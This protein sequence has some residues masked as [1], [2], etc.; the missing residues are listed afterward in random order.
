MS[1]REGLQQGRVCNKA[2]GLCSFSPK[3]LTINRLGIDTLFTAPQDHPCPGYFL[4]L[5][6]VLKK[7]DP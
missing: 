6:T 7:E 3:V 5:T 2:N 1:A 4:W